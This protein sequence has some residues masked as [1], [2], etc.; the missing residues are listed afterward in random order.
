V[1]AGH[2]RTGKTTASYAIANTVHNLRNWVIVWTAADLYAALKPDGD[3]NA[4]DH[5]D[6]WDERTDPGAPTA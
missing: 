6:P 3:P 2:S 1:L 5:D 4:Y